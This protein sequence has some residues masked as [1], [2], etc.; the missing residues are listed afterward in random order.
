MLSTEN[1]TGKV[2]FDILI[3]G[4]E[5]TT[6][7]FKG[8]IKHKFQIGPGRG[9]EEFDMYKPNLLFT[10]NMPDEC[11]IDHSTCKVVYDEEAL[12]PILTYKNGILRVDK[13]SGKVG[14][15]VVTIDCYTTG[16]VLA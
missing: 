1:K 7:I 16:R 9:Y 12:G 6:N 14:K 13:T 15:K 2:D 8:L 11:P 10:S 5:N 4:M 3:C